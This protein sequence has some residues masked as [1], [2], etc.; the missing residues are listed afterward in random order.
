MVCHTGLLL[1]HF[2]IPAA[3]FRDLFL[4]FFFFSAIKVLNDLFVLTEWLCVCCVRVLC[5]LAILWW[6]LLCYP[7]HAMLPLSP[8]DVAA[9]SLSLS[10]CLPSVIPSPPKQPHHH[11]K[12]PK[13][14]I[15]TLIH[16]ITPVP[17]LPNDLASRVL[18]ERERAGGR[19]GCHCLTHNPRGAIKH[20][21]GGEHPQP[22]P[23]GDGEI[24]GG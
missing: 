4:F 19:G 9:H 2:A 17:H 6:L 11:H 10:S 20:C 18:G 15:R 21:P 3:H 23:G 5:V 14:P 12:H 7:L 1:R 16:P 13:T 8:A 24:S 22:C